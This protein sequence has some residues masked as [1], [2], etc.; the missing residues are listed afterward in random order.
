MSDGD[1]RGL[2]RDCVS[3][4]R[5]WRFMLMDL[6]HEECPASVPPS[7]ARLNSS[8]RRP[9]TIAGIC[10]TGCGSGSQAGPRRGGRGLAGAWGGPRGETWRDLSSPYQKLRDENQNFSRC[11]S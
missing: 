1:L 5:T 3:T 2:L 9:P 7:W 11:R 8:A 6:L 10:A 4:G